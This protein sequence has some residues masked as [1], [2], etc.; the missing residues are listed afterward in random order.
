MDGG[1]A[2]TRHEPLAQHGGRLCVAR[3]LYPYAP[4]PWIDL[5]TGINPRPYRAARS[6]SIALGSL[7]EPSQLAELERTAA[8]TFGVDDARRVVAVPGTELGLRLLPTLL[9]CSSAAIAGPTYSSHF[10]AWQRYGAVVN[11]VARATLAVDV[12]NAAAIVV[13]NPNNPDG[14]Q[15]ERARLLDLH[16][17]A[18][19]RQG[20]LI[21]DEAFVDLEPALS[22][23]DLAGSGRAPQLVALR[24]FGKFYGLAGVRLGFVIAG[25]EVADRLRGLLGD[26]PLSA[27]ALTAG[28]AAY[29]DQAWATKTRARLQA[30]AEHLDRLLVRAGFDIVGGTSLYRLA[31]HAR[32]L[33]RFE[34]LLR[35][36]IL[37]RPFDYDAT[38]LRF[39]LPYGASAW[40]RVA[41]ALTS[42]A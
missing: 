11:Y 13:V 23:C 33:E 34:H 7:P 4:Q 39:G 6:A 1:A 16:D 15:L 12:P 38:L 24:S 27:D 30:A 35:A 10:D 3:R 36:G 28:I 29:G 25:S 31:R 14:A 20:W 5:S 2:D 18:R 8:R 9:K 32:A 21:V 22:I 26:W 40:R 42:V 37:T 41:D 17:T 19:T